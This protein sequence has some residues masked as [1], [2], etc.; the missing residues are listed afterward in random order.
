V[1]A[2][3][4]LARVQL[5]LGFRP[6][7]N[8]QHGDRAIGLVFEENPPIS[9]AEAEDSL[10]FLFDKPNDVAVATGAVTGKRVQDVD[11]VGPA[12]PPQIGARRSTPVKCHSPNSRSTSV[13]GTVGE[14]S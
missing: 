13:C 14:W 3:D 5:F 12:D 9:A 8:S 2:V 11:R 1:F 10:E 6:M 4:P 7:Q